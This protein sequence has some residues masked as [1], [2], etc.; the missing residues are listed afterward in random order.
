M[1]YDEA[2]LP[3]ALH[4]THHCS[5]AQIAV[6]RAIV[7]VLV[8]TAASLRRR[9]GIPWWDFQASCGVRTGA[10]HASE[11][12]EVDD[13]AVAIDLANIDHTARHTQRQMTA[14]LTWKIRQPAPIN[15]L[16]V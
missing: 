7:A 15:R 2:V 11:G 12:A 8:G 10:S 14:K 5:I 4:V 9:I 16:D 1:K 6:A 13:G 3:A